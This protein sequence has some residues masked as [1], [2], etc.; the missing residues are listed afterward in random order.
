LVTADNVNAEIKRGIK[1]WTD[2]VGWDDKCESQINKHYKIVFKSGYLA[3]TADGWKT[4]GQTFAD[5]F[6]AFE[7]LVQIGVQSNITSLEQTALV[8]EFNHLLYFSKFGILDNDKT[9]AYMAEHNL[10]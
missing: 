9:H 7:G 1:L 10:P 8:H 4:T 5:K 3:E 6:G 2:A